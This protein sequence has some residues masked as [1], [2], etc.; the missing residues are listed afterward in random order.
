MT[1]RIRT[2]VVGLGYFG[3]FHARHHALNPHAE[4]VAVVDPNAER[5]GLAA[6]DHG[7]AALQSHRDLFGKV[8]AVAIAASTSAHFEIARDCLEAGLDVLVEKPITQTV[9]Q[10][11]ALIAAARANDRILQV[12]HIERFSAAFTALCE[13]VSEPVLIESRRLV[14]LRPRANDVSVVAD[15]M[16]H[17]IDLVMRLVDA[18]IASITADGV[19][20]VNPTVDHVTARIAFANGAVAVLAAG[21]VNET[22][23]RTLRVVE[24]DRNLLCDLAE[25]RLTAIHANGAVARMGEGAISTTTRDVERHDNLGVQTAA[26]LNSCRTRQPPDV[27]GETG[28]DALDI[29]QRIEQCMLTAAS[30]P[31]KEHPRVA[32]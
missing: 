9:E 28:R 24:R 8:D 16:I 5:A 14:P 31:R 7:C 4:L 2:A 17:D 1:S 6:E 15:L 23:E 20:M 13:Q 19:A 11:D 10:A 32:S 26:F 27:S 18:R 30:E 3:S 29:V 12:G 21:R 22:G 25:S